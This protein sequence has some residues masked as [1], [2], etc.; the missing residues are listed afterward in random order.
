VN[1]N[2]GIARSFF[3]DRHSQKWIVTF[4]P[5]SGVV[6]ESLMPMAL[7]SV[8]VHETLIESLALRQ[9]LRSKQNPSTVIHDARISSKF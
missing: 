7:P 9:E 8:I 2:I 4:D 5:E 6:M 1:N 3:G